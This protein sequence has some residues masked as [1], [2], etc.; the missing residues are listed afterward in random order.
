M[1]ARSGIRHALWIAWK[2]L[3]YISRNRMGLVMLILMPLF[4]MGMVGYIFPSNSGMSHVPVSYTHLTLP[5]N[6]EV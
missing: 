1:G 2:D 6:R 5:T 4:M 3:L